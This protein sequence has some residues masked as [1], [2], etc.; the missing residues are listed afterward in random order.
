MVLVAQ[1]FGGVIS[2]IEYDANVAEQ[3]NINFRAGV[4]EIIDVIVGDARDV[5]YTQVNGEI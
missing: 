2:P 4:S 5:R 3:A 1:P